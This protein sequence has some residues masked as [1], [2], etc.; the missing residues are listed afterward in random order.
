MAAALQQDWLDHIP[1]EYCKLPLNALKAFTVH[2]IGLYLD[3]ELAVLDN[4]AGT[5]R[6]YRGLAD[7]VGFD[8]LEIDVSTIYNIWLSLS[9]VF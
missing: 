1:T 2:R 8:Y 3:Q 7:L 4:N 6:D 9:S 5:M